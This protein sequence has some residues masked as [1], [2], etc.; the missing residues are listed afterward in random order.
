MNENEWIDFELGFITNHQFQTKVAREL[1]GKRKEKH[2][3]QL[4]KQKTRLNPQLVMTVD[5]MSKREKK[6]NKIKE[7]KASGKNISK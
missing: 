7:E 5:E 4:N 6:K 1:Y 2:I 3:K